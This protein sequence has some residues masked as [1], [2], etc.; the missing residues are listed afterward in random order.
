M[1]NKKTAGPAGT[2][3]EME[4]KKIGYLKPTNFV[5]FLIFDQG[6]YFKRFASSIAKHANL[7]VFSP[8]L[9]NDFT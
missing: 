4:N 2:N 7:Q 5:I 3:L 1:E 9:S 6:V 8:F